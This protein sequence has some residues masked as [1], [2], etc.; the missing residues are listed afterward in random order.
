[1]E[2]IRL[3]RNT[4]Q[5][6]SYA[7]KL[8][9]L[10]VAEWSYLSWAERIVPKVQKDI[11]FYCKEWIDLHSGDYFRSVVAYLRGQ[12]DSLEAP[13]PRPTHLVTPSPLPPPM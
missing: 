5:S 3:M 6:S 7:E 4:A 12:L 13:P 11:P 8:A 10:I 1:M 9:V 2:F